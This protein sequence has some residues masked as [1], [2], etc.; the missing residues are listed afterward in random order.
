L[1]TR[2]KCR[3]YPKPIAVDISV[4]NAGARMGLLSTFVA[5]ILSQFSDPALRAL[6]IRFLE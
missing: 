4:F 2:G 5:P 6:G 1:L 3:D